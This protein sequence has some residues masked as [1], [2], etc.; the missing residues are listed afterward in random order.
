MG[1]F[2]FILKTSNPFMKINQTGPQPIKVKVV[3]WVINITT[4]TIAD[5]PLPTMAKPVKINKTMTVAIILIPGA[6]L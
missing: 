2:Q 5:S 3:K 4:A 6:I 1:R